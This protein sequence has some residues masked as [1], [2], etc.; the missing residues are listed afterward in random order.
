MV[1]I[2]V[3]RGTRWQHHQSS[4]QVA[5]PTVLQ[6][7]SINKQHQNVTAGRV[8]NVSYDIIIIQHTMIL[9]D[10]MDVMTWSNCCMKNVERSSSGAA[11]TK[12]H[13]A[14]AL[15]GTSAVQ[16]FLE[17]HRWNCEIFKIVY[18]TNLNM[19]SIN[20]SSLLTMLLLCRAG[21]CIYCIFSHFEAN[22]DSQFHGVKFRW[23][24]PLMPLNPSN[25][26]LDVHQRH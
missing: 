24:F 4:Y 15:L 7:K 20:T 11:S 2:T 5:K 13:R 19:F 17:N 12:H 3:N 6:R 14:G 10:T 8:W 9:H 25:S 21:H 23:S 16:L 1:L 22:L 26:I 18:D